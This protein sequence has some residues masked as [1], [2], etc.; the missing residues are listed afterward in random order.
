MWKECNRKIFSIPTWLQETGFA[1]RLFFYFFFLFSSFQF[2][3]VLFAMFPWGTGSPSALRFGHCRLRSKPGL[4]SVRGCAIC[5]GKR[6]SNSV[7]N[8]PADLEL[9]IPHEWQRQYN[10]VHMGL[11]FSQNQPRLSFSLKHMLKSGEIE[12]S[13]CFFWFL[14]LSCLVVGGISL[15]PFLFSSPVQKEVIYEGD[16]G[17]HIL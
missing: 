3:L 15:P 2:P 12:I 1:A 16:K 14:L 8:S 9:L 13:C 17:E 5:K 10:S 4:M 7:T 11:F 6:K